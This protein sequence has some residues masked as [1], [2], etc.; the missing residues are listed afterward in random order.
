[1]VPGTRAVPH[2]STESIL[3]SHFPVGARC[4]SC[5]SRLLPVVVRQQSDPVG[6]PP[7]L[8]AF[9][10]NCTTTRLSSLRHWLSGHRMYLANPWGLIGLL[11]LP[12]ILII[13]L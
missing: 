13:H 2:T 6:P 10:P 11:A 4:V 1:F 8:G 7:G 3:F 12:A 9:F 5:E